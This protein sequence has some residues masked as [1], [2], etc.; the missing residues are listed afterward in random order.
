MKIT[1]FLFTQ[2][3]CINCHVDLNKNA[4]GSYLN[5]TNPRGF[6]KNKITFF[7]LIAS[8]GNNLLFKFL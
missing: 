1:I 7:L 5:D 2:L 4:F 8:V 6:F 3:T